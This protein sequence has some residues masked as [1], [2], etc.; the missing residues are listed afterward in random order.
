MMEIQQMEMSAKDDAVIVS[1]KK[2]LL[3][4]DSI[5]KY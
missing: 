1:I 4:L 2:I 3:F 5:I